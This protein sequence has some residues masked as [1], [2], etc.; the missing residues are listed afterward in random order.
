MKLVEEEEDDEEI[1]QTW[2]QKVRAL[3]NEKKEL[4]KRLDT[5]EEEDS[6]QLKSL[7]NKID[8]L[9]AENNELKA[10]IG[11]L[12]AQVDM[13]DQN[14]ST[15]S[16]FDGYS[17]ARQNRPSIKLDVLK[18]KINQMVIEND[19]LKSTIARLRWAS[20]Y[21]QNVE[22]YN[23]E[24]E[25]IEEEVEDFMSA[26]DISQLEDQ[27]N[28]LKDLLSSEQSESKKWKEMYESLKKEKEEST[29][30][31]KNNKNGDTFDENV[32]YD[33]VLNSTNVLKEALVKGSGVVGTKLK[34]IFDKLTENDSIFSG[35]ISMGINA[36][37]TVFYELNR[38]LQN[39][40]QEL[41]DLK[42][43]LSNGNKKISNKMSKLLER[44]VRKLQDAGNKLLS[45]EERLKSRVDAFSNRISKL[46]VDLDNKWNNLLN[47]LSDRYSKQHKSSETYENSEPKINWFFERAKSRRQHQTSPSD[48]ETDG[49]R[50][51]NI[52][53]DRVVIDDSDVDQFSDS[54]V[55]EEEA[56]E[57]WFLRKAKKP[58]INNDFEF[59]RPNHKSR[60]HSYRTKQEFAQK[61]DYTSRQ[62]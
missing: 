42:D 52:E 60:R 58:K 39:K 23:S 15:V 36:T 49:N 54:G 40:W 43:V 14:P 57:N 38:R 7:N 51:S 37:Q 12:E 17:T 27:L 35:D 31:S 21:H 11:Q 32:I 3:E 34:E 48:T 55:E 45:K 1:V 6:I 19:E 53:F 41:Q 30:S 16:A 22:E 20:N 46:I 50:K 25:V 10:A 47:K 5:D 33:W 24:E 44:T 2:D 56:E 61:F 26:E 13:V 4:Q 18:Q 28:Q 59:E 9:L 29:K 62:R 8:E